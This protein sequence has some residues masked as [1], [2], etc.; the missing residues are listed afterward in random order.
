MKRK[1]AETPV[2]IGFFQSTG[3]LALTNE[4]LVLVTRFTYNLWAPTTFNLTNR[5][6]LGVSHMRLQRLGTMVHLLGH[7]ERIERSDLEPIEIRIAFF[8]FLDLLF[9]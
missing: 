8:F 1:T 6:H 5:H 2:A 9:V 7:L 3:N 4:H